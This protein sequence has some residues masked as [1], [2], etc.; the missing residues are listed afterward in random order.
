MHIFQSLF[1][2]LSKSINYFQKKLL[3]NQFLNSFKKCQN[4][5]KIEIFSKIFMFI[6]KQLKTYSQFKKCLT[7]INFGIYFSLSFQQRLFNL[8][9]KLPRYSFL[10]DFKGFFRRNRDEV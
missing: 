1:N 8:I 2:D 3:S 10:N 5:L 9:E 7:R 6:F 4:K